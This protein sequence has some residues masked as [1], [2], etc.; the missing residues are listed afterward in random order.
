[1]P[2][3]PRTPVLVGAGQITHR[4]GPAGPSPLELMVLAARA[5]AADAGAGG[6]TLLAKAASVGV[7]DLF[8]WPVRDP[9]AALAAELGLQPAETIVSARGGNG[10]IALLGDLASRIAA[11]QLDVA[12]LAGG[13]AGTAFQ[14][15]MREGRD[16]G[17]GVQPDGT[18]PTRTV[19]ADRDPGDPAELEA[20]LIAPIFWYPLFEHAVRGAAGRTRDEHQAH[21]GELWLRFADVARGN[22]HAWSRE[23]PT[24]AVEIAEP[25]PGNRRVSDPYTKAMNANI[26]VDQGAALLLCSAG[27]ARAAGIAPERWVFVEA[28]AGAHDHWLCGEREAFHRSPA[29]AACGRAALAHADA[30]IDDVALLDLYS[31]FPSAVQIAAAEL[32]VDPLDPARAPTVTGGLAFAGGPANGY[33]MHSLATEVERIRERPADRGLATAV[34]WYLTKHGVALLAGRPGVRP[35]AHHDV[36]AA[37]DAQPRRAIVPAAEAC[38]GEVEAHTAIFDRDGSATMGIVALLLPD[39]RRAFGR[40]HD[41]DAIAELQAMEPLGRRARTDGAATFSWA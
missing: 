15:A 6:D 32:G 41:A 23:P 17:W 4:D 34:G 37:V 29:I 33:V 22:P 36:Q 21:L 30:A 5:A 10:P 8:S 2:L 28:T 12:L 18:A 38:A 35:F 26:T 24:S 7:V 3:D 27:A 13:E 11:G 31:C 39:G 9:G 19:G 1:M 14:A 20:G 25:G 40:T 16:P